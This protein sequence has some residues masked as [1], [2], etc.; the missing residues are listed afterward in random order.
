MKLDIIIEGEKI[1]DEN[2]MFSNKK[3]LLFNW[4][5]AVSKALLKKFLVLNDLIKNH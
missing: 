5:G 2:G 4:D 3:A 1:T